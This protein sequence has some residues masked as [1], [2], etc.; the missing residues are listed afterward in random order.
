MSSEKIE[1]A[2]IRA[3][4]SKRYTQGSVN[5]VIQRAS[6]LVFDTVADKKRA[7]AGR[8]DGELFYGRRGTLTHFSLQEAMTELEGGAGCALYPCGA[9]AVA[10]AIL[11]FVSAGIMC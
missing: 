4:R 7:T 1:T 8:A 3:G 9:A 6:S 10:N 11:A 5:T 2:L